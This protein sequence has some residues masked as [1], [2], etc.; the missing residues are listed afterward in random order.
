MNAKESVLSSS[1]W[2]IGADTA[3]KANAIVSSTSPSETYLQWS[4]K[5]MGSGLGIWPYL[6][7]YLVY[8]AGLNEGLTTEKNGAFNSTGELE[9]IFNN[10]TCVVLIDNR[11]TNDGWGTN[12]SNGS[13]DAQ[14]AKNAAIALG[15]PSGMCIFVDVETNVANLGNYLLNYRNTLENSGSV[16]YKMGVY[17]NYSSFS[18]INSQFNLSNT[19]TWIAKWNSSLVYPNWPHEYPAEVDGKGIV[20]LWQFI[21]NQY[22]ARTNVGTLSMDLNLTTSDR[23]DQKTFMYHPNF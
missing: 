21:S 4:Q 22:Q 13:A 11:G 17:T 10:R 23:N 1:T 6:G 19:Y 20:K 5:Q 9:T 14:K 7:R 8:R 16:R 2:V 12:G 3:G 15:I 18:T